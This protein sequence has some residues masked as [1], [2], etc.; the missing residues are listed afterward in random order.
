MVILL[1]ESPKSSISY[2]SYTVEDSAHG[3]TTRRIFDA[4]ADH[5]QVLLFLPRCSSSKHRSAYASN[6]LHCIMKE[7]IEMSFGAGIRAHK[8]YRIWSCC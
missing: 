3:L 1:P 7:N 6:E 5:Y 2:C 4:I 8:E